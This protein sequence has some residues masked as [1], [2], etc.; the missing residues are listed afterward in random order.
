[1]DGPDMTTTQATRE[2]DTR[3]A[4]G[5]LDG[6]RVIEV[7]GPLTGYAGKLLGDM[8]ADV[9]LV[10][11]PDGASLRRHGPLLENA[12]ELER[13]LTFAYLHTSKRGVTLDLD[14]ADGQ[15]LFRKL[16]ATASV[17]LESEPVARMEARGLGYKALAAARPDLVYTSVQPFGRGG[18]YAD[19][20]AT[21]LVLAAMGGLLYMGGYPD[22][23]P[24]RAHGEQAL[25][26]AGQFAAIGTMLAL[27]Q[28]EQTGQ[29]QL[30][31]VSAQECVVMAL[32]NAIQF[33][34]LQGDVRRRI[35]GDQRWAGSGV[36]PCSD[37][38]FYLL[39][40]GGVGLGNFWK[41]LTRWLVEEGVPNAE[42]LSGEQWTD[43]S[44]TQAQEAKTRFIEIFTPF[45]KQHTKAEL[46]QASKEWRF[47][48]CPVSTPADLVDDTQLRARD[49]FIT[50]PHPAS[51]RQLEMPR[52]PFLLSATPAR[53]SRPAPRLG[54]HNEEI[55]GGL[56]LP[57]RDLETLFT[58]G[59]I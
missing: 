23:E 20:V 28:A 59:V 4:P 24:L 51:G 2:R 52:T 55:L 13:S 14:T 42:E 26:A 25:L 48:M 57:E 9:I 58:V 5:P 38:D 17:I 22:S 27:L 30:V 45:T 10:E 1:M 49:F 12:P 46:Y 32:E 18:P 21:D 33:Y 6:V 40:G 35:G 31:D 36:Y 54:E 15:A 16:A 11:P 44:W 53:V 8:G 34:D 50:V 41:Q 7:A 43:Y 29:G 47:P 37:G 3:A 19:Y 56:G 39:C